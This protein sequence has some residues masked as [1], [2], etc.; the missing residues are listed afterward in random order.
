M[1]QSYWMTEYETMLINL[2]F[3]Y[4]TISNEELKLSSKKIRLKELGFSN[5]EIKELLQG[6]Q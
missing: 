3:A 4:M 5:P 1:N 6:G 2:R